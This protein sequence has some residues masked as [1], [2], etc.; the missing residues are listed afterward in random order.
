MSNIKFFALGGLGDTGKNLYVLEI[1]QK[2][3]ILD[4]GLQHPSG[5]LLGVDALVPDISYL[6]ARKNDIVGIFLS[7]A[8]DKNIGALPMLLQNFKKPI[9]ATAFT[10]EMAKDLL[11]EYDMD[12]NDYDFHVVDYKQAIKFKHFKVEF[13]QTT[14]SIPLSAAIVI[15]TNDG[16]IVYATDYTFD[17]NVGQFFQTDFQSLVRVADK[18]VLA[19]LGESKGA[20]H[21]GHSSTDGNLKRII[22]KTIKQAKHRII[23]NMY[24]TEL[25][26]IQL[27][28]N[29]AI[30]ANKK[31]A[32]IGRKAQRLVY[33][34][35][36]MGY[37]EIPEESLVN[38]RF[39]DQN[40]KNEFDDVVFLVTGE[41][42]EPF[43]MLQRMAK[44]YDRL[45]NLIE[46]D[47]ILSMSVPVIGTEK[48]SA[49]TFNILS[50]IGC[51]VIKVDHKYL[52]AFHAASEDIK[53]MYALLKPKYVIPINGEYRMLKAQ[54]S[55]ALDY[56]INEENILMLDNGEMVTFNDGHLDK[57][58]D[59]VENGVVM[60]DGNFETDLNSIV[61]KEREL[62]S[63]DGYLIIA[64]NIDAKRKKMLNK[65]EV[66][67]RGYLFMK[68]N[69]E[70]IRQIEIIYEL[71]T[72]KQF[73][74]QKLDWK[75]YKDNLRHQ[76]QR[77]LLKT[78]R[79]KPI[80]IPMI[81]D[82]D[83]NH[84]CRVI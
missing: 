16:A 25:S 56:G 51:N 46:T 31:I 12:P 73:S 57:H 45:V 8:H 68:D 7:H 27:V 50:E 53:L 34:G 64:A 3:I 39:I 30:E 32:I 41:R 26:T 21:F 71:E 35:E 52:S 78:T 83:E 47:T 65:P 75:E 11:K 9:Y 59:L 43:F 70:I 63:Q 74:K 20:V 62:L 28:I 36:K 69:E 72:K 55:I 2:L 19:F 29:E 67:S 15:H 48:I 79:R 22:R 54:A 40:N 77:Y 6:Q 84:Q 66:V 14:H 38:L 42:H 60:I 18:G 1:E 37:I 82:T 13:I 61:L 23:V 4:S 81:I 49:K 58:R 76:V 44:G 17:Q 10:N 80:I 24:S 33:I 5:D